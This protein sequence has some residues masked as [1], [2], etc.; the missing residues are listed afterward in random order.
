MPAL[1]AAMT[2]LA[3]LE[4]P[5]TANVPHASMVSILR[6]HTLGPLYLW[7]TPLAPGW[8]GFNLS[9]IDMQFAGG[10]KKVSLAAAAGAWYND[11]S[12]MVA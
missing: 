7:K 8:Q 5:F 3:S 12:G 1:A 4:V 9:A 2:I 6:G 11:L 10:V